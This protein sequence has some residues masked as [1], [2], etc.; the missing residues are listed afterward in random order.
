MHRGPEAPGRQRVKV[1]EDRKDV[2]L[3]G[4]APVRPDCRSDHPTATLGPSRVL[5]EVPPASAGRRPPRVIRP[6]T[7][8]G[9]RGVVRNHLR[10]RFGSLRLSELDRRDVERVHA[11]S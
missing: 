2:W 9:Y 1:T 3:W 10:P 6:T 4:P 11:D 7:F 5:W 8:V